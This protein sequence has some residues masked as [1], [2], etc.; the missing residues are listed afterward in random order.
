MKNNFFWTQYTIKKTSVQLTFSSGTCKNYEKQ[1]VC[2]PYKLK[3]TG[4]ELTLSSGTLKTYT[5]HTLLHTP[6]NQGNKCWA[7][8]ELG[9]IKSLWKTHTLL[10]PYKIKKTGVETFGRRS[11]ESLENTKTGDA[12]K[13]VWKTQ[14][15]GWLKMN[16]GKHSKKWTPQN[17]DPRQGSLQM[18]VRKQ[19]GNNQTRIWK[20]HN[21]DPRQGSLKT[22]L[23]VTIRG[24]FGKAKDTI[25]DRGR[26]K[27]G[28]PRW[29]G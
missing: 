21:H 29:V 7:H 14:T 8:V 24:H 2:T 22:N 5:K 9:N 11:Q 18:R 23:P 26:R 1:G 28:G 16:V 13:K 6:Q 10:T 4:V 20:T 17:H 3:K 25:L 27:G 15:Q 12:H 19:S